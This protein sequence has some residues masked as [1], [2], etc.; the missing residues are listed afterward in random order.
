MIYETSSKQ[1][2]EI[3]AAAADSVAVAIGARVKN[4]HPLAVGLNLQ[5]IAQT[6]ALATQPRRDWE[7]E[8]SVMGRGMNTDLFG[9][10]LAA[11][12]R[13]LALQT[14]DA[15]A[16]EHLTFTVPFD[17][18]NFNPV[19]IVAADAQGVALDHQAPGLG[20]EAAHVADAAAD[21]NVDAFHGNAT[22]G[23]GIAFDHQ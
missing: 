1:N 8:M 20:H 17:V 18:K 19:E 4:P 14:Y 12:A 5:T 9:K 11:G 15:Q 3:L 6:C 7:T 22:S 2:A 23:T 13:Q 21:H 10:T 16:A